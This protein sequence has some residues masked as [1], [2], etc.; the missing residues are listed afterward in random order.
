[1]QGRRDVQKRI[2][3]K[4]IL[5]NASLVALVISVLA[6]STVVA[7]GD[8]NTSSCGNEAIMGFKA[9]LPDCRAYEMVT[10]S[11]KDGGVVGTAGPVSVDGS[12]IATKANSA[13]GGTPDALYA[14]TYYQFERAATG[15]V[16]T[17]LSPPASL[18]PS[19]E[20][21]DGVPGSLVAST[22]LQSS[23]WKVTT[24]AA[25]GAEEAFYLQTTPGG[26]LAFVGPEQLPPSVGG[27]FHRNAHL[28]GASAN[29]THLLVNILPPSITEREQ[30]FNQ[31]WPGA[32]TYPVPQLYDYTGTGNSEPTLVG[33]SNQEKLAGKPHINEGAHLISECG[34]TLGGVQEGGHTDVYN[35]VSASG[36]TE[37][38]SSLAGP[39]SA[40]GQTGAGPSVSELYARIGGSRTAAISEPSLEIPGRLCTGVCREDENEENGH[41]HSQGDFAGAS[42]D[43]AKVFFTTSQPLV[44]EDSNG[45]LNLYEAQFSGPSITRLVQVSHDPHGSEAAEVQGV[46]RVSENGARVYFVATGVLTNSK[47]AEGQE[48]EAGADNLYVYDTEAATTKFVGKLLTQA[49]EKAIRAEEEAELTRIGQEVE[50]I[51]EP[52]ELRA[53]ELEGKA[54][55]AEA[56]G[57]LARSVEERQH[58]GQLRTEGEASGRQL[59]SDTEGS[60]GPAGQEE[61]DGTQNGTLEQDKAVWSDTDERPAQATPDGR[62]LV[63][64]SS[65]RLTGA[66]D[67]SKVAQLFEYDAES[68]TLVR[69]S[70]GHDGYNDN[71]NVAVA[72]DA[73]HIPRPLYSGG[74]QPTA[75]A[76]GLAL[77]A[78]GSRV[79]FESSDGLAPQAIIGSPSVYEFRNGNVYLISDGHAATTAE[80]Q[81]SVKLIGTD[82]SG[83]DA[84]F[85]TA[86]QLVPEDG[87]TQVDIYDAREGGGFPSSVSP[88]GCAAD[89]CQGPLSATPSLPVTSGS[90]TQAGGENLPPTVS[91]PTIKPQSKPLTRVQKLAKALQACRKDKSKSTRLSCEKQA[92]KRYGAK[93]NA[94]AK[95]KGGK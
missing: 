38:F 18:F 49:E 48:P 12:R 79:F 66:E 65:A 82:A 68:E 80:G 45:G 8:A 67:T 58:A 27:H 91:K 35:A 56:T 70:V 16:T 92:R 63:F 44:N 13:F 46:V 77:S 51:E 11:F 81:P 53:A 86:E 64:V 47:N 74:F 33:V 15:W 60:R 2:R 55:E 14:T 40:S 89:A 26:P 23:V 37:F 93:P 73:P 20:T 30:G 52:F 76:T 19:A 61:Q 25:L 71:G 57:E 28:A 10:P 32:P 88:V 4:P 43:G 5:R 78:D 90:S 62:F 3:G 72:K 36:E 41:T 1:M 39:C 69:V 59:R 34:T 87:D 22:D 94:K 24:S 83:Q 9:S 85:T 50:A 95:R 7:A 75:A 31:P 6:P 84:F 21:P 54:E 17:A 29:L 42:E